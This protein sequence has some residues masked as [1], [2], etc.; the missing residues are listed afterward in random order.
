MAIILIKTLTNPISTGGPVQSA[1]PTPTRYD[2]TTINRFEKTSNPATTSGRRSFSNCVICWYVL[3]VE[4]SVRVR[5]QSFRRAQSSKKEGMEQQSDHKSA[6]KPFCLNDFVFKL[7]SPSGSQTDKVN[8][9]IRELVIIPRLDK[10]R[11]QRKR[12][13]CI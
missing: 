1:R 13:F 7:D 2:D 5:F 6:A 11:K 8:P 9:C 10:I 4:L 12:L 3:H